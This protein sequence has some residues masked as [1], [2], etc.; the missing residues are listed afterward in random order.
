M[1]GRLVRP[2]FCQAQTF[3]QVSEQVD[4]VCWVQEAEEAVLSAVQPG[5]EQVGEVSAGSCRR[6][7]LLLYLSVK[8]FLRTQ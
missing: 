6:P 5:G 2:A 7:Q 8:C 1:A 3:E 4:S